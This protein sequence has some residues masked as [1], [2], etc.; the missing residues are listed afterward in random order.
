MSQGEIFTSL[1]NDTK[2]KFYPIEA[3]ISFWEAV[4]REKG[5]NDFLRVKNNIIKRNTYSY[6]CR[7][8][9]LKQF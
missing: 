7:P 5:R 2:I 8:N 6:L 3:I 9:V 1:Q 4:F